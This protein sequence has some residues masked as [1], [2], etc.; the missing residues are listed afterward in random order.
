MPAS[1]QCST[2]A[3]HFARRLA[4]SAWLALLFVAAGTGGDAAELEKEYKIKA[5]FLYNF[6]KFVEWP[7]ERFASETAPIVIGVLGDNQFGTELENIVQDRKANG[8]DVLIV[9][10]RSIA[11]ATGVHILFISAREVKRYAGS[12]AVKRPGVLTVGESD[13]FENAGGV[14]TFTT[15][16]DK[17]RFKINMDAANCSGLRI[18]AQLQKLAMAVRK[19]S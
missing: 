9:R 14:V 11:D 18:S 5:A 3:A 19:K 10:L 16:D 12:D 6:A 8:R 13:A 4:R 2:H 15:P 7:A 1:L 17:V